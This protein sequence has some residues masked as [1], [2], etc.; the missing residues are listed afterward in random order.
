MVRALI[1]MLCPVVAACGDDRSDDRSIPVAL[2]RANASAAPVLAAI[3]SAAGTPAPAVAVAVAAVWTYAPSARAAW[4]GPP[5]GPA[6]LALACERGDERADRLAVVRYAPADKGA[7]ALFAIQ[8]SKG[9][10]RLP[11]SA[12]KVG[13]RGY[14]W[15]GVLDPAD[16]RAEVLLGSGLKATVPGGGEL[17]LAPLGAA[18]A[19]VSECILRQARD[20]PSTGSG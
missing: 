5:D 9:I 16:P 15:R 4:Y 1:L 2:P 7:R 8:G 10:L 11:V 18:A 20:D 3:T 6:L 14:V 17:E 13:K 19:L 12:V